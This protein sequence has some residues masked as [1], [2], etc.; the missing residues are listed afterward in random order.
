MLTLVVILMGGVLI[1]RVFVL[2]IVEGENYLNE[3]S[4]KIK[5][6]VLSPVPGERFLTETGSFSLITI[7]LIPLP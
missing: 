2:Q 4:L 5:R 3:F 7:W 6:N 1:H